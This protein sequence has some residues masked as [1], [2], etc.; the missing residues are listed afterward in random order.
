MAPEHDLRIATAYDDLYD[1]PPERLVQAIE[2]LGYRGVISHYVGMSHYF[3]LTSGGELDPTRTLNSAALAW[4]QDLARAAK[5]HGYEL[6]WSISYEILD[7]FCPEAWKQRAYDGTQALTAW[8]PPSTLVSPSNS[9]AITFLKN[10]ALELA[11]ISQAAGLQPQ[12]QIGEPWWWVTPGGAIC[13]YDDAAKVALGGEPVEIANVR[14]ALTP[15]QTDLLDQ[16]GALLAASTATI[17]S[18]VKAAAPDARTLLLTYLPTV[19][20]PTAP[21]L[22]RANLPVVWA[23]PAFDVLQLED[24]EWV[25]SGRSG[26]RAAAYAEVEQR[27]GYTS[28]EQHYFSGFVAD[29]ANREQWRAVVDAAVEA[30]DRDCAEVLIWALP[31]VLRDGLTIFERSKRWRRSTTSIFRSRSARRRAS[32]RPSRPTS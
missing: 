7:I 3:G 14:A 9:Y 8:D 13:L 16:A 17:A 23:K 11:G 6:I 31:Q 32:P 20:D 12:V 21:E 5:A 25:T 19:L 15:E 28:A 30:V 18:A 2:R 22:R 4:H 26:M 29:A 24:Y 27:L 10:V 1:V